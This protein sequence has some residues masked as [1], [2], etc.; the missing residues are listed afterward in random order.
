MGYTHYWSFK[1]APKGQAAKI[2][3]DYQLAIRQCQRI[4]KTYNDRMRKIDEKHPDRLSGYSAHTKVKQYGG[5]NF[6]GTGEL[7]HEQFT[8][9]EH[10]SQNENDFCK[11]ARKPYDTVVVACLIVL[12]HYL[13]D[14][15]EV[16]SDG[17]FKDWE[18]GLDFASEVL[19]IKDLKNPL[20]S[21][22]ILELVR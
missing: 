8:M 22:S 9:R 20:S 6:N 19:R 15:F 17:D 14:C 2:E 18:T 3:T 5:L 4:I 1:K 11:T 12:K 10:F 16:S 21:S 7:S 13:K